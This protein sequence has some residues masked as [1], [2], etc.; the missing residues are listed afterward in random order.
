MDFNNNLTLAT[1]LKLG[2]TKAYDFLMETYY[3]SLC[4]YAFTLT[5]DKGKAEDIVQN[6][7][8]KVWMNKKNINSHFIIKN[9]VYKSVY[10]QFIDQFRKNKPVIYLEKKY[11]EALDLV[12]ENDYE[13]LNELTQLV[14]KEIMNLPPKC[15]EIFILNKKDGLTH[16]E[17]SEYLNI[18]IKTVEGHM[19]RAFK[20]LADKL[21]PQI[22]AILFL[23]YDFKKEMNQVK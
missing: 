4:R 10:N 2:N 17:I 6:V 12:V 8:V 11:L 7:F 15:R 23:L 3:K 19:T 1:Q 18:S 22:D 14:N 21:N 16:I 20:V 13:D 5:H 9:Y